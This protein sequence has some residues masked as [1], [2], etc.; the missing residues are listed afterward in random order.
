MSPVSIER[1]AGGNAHER[2]TPAAKLPIVAA[3]DA[4]AIVNPD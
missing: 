4:A 2:W 3:V 1:S